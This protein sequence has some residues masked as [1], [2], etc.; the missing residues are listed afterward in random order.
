MPCFTPLPSFLGNFTAS[1]KNKRVV[2][3]RTKYNLERYSMRTPCGG[4]RSCRI[5]KSTEWALRCEHEMQL[6]VDNC[7]LTLTYSNDFLPLLGNTGV[8]TLDKKAIPL[9]MKKLRRRVT[10]P[11][12]KYFI[13]ED[14]RIRYYYGG[15]YGDKTSR[16]H[17]HVILFGFDF[18]DKYFPMKRPGGNFIYRSKFLEELWPYGHSSVGTATFQSAGYV[19]RYCMKKV[20]GK[21]AQAHYQ[22]IDSSTGEVFDRQPEFN[23]MSR[24]GGIGK[25]WFDLYMSDVYPRDEVISRA[26]K[27]FKPPRYYDG[28]Y[29][30]IDPY[31][32]EVIKDKRRV[33]GKKQAHNATED[34]LAVRSKCFD[35]KVGMLKRDVD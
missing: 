28:L 6:H 34:R 30:H 29:E 35:A 12:D 14:Y 16:P 9:F 19:A 32:L 24:R 10:N 27:R 11:D 4:C 13:S 7:F 2:L 5:S 33:E 15:E 21:N 31:S 26:G 20:T 3:P 25:A 1:G 8:S 17:Y 22:V 18:K 23:D